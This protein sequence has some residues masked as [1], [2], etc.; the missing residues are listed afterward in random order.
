MRIVGEIPHPLYKITLFQWNG[1]YIIKFESGPCEQSYKISE[2]DVDEN[3]LYE[4]LDD[5]FMKKI[6][7]RFHHM[8]EDLQTLLDKI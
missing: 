3:D 1:K 7:S 4:L 6:S 8:H 2:F 5:E